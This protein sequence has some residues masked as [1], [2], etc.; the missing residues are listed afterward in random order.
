M[1]T[2]ANLSL[3]QMYYPHD[4]LFTYFMVPI[5]DT[6]F[7]VRP[8]PKDRLHRQTSHDASI[9]LLARPELPDQLPTLPPHNGKHLVHS[10]PYPGIGRLKLHVHPHHVIVNAAMKWENLR[11]RPEKRRSVRLRRERLREEFI[12]NFLLVS[13][14]NHLLEG[15]TGSEARAQVERLLE[16]LYE[17]YK[18]WTANLGDY[19]DADGPG[20][21]AGDND[22]IEDG[23]DENEED[24][25]YE[26]P[27][28]QGP[29]KRPLTLFT[30]PRLTHTI[31]RTTSVPGLPA[32]ISV[33][34]SSF[35]TF[36]TRLKRTGRRGSKSGFRTSPIAW[37]IQ[38]CD[39]SRCLKLASLTT[40]QETAA[41]APDGELRAYQTEPAR[42][43]DDVAWWPIWNRTYSKVPMPDPW[44]LG[45]T[46]CSNDWAF[47]W[48]NWW[49]PTYR[50]ETEAEVRAK[51]GKRRH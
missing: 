18:A 4:V 35:P 39:S 44:T 27:S 26:S 17:I 11:S 51:A 45:R 7:I 30:A 21:H 49:L 28:P 13:H 40:L 8:A 22:H 3:S 5:R 32:L 24:S 1:D 46:H 43:S 38:R 6:G 9:P 23:T 25:S 14:T 10:Y 19:A 42:A 37:T 20:D 16:Q 48:G 36:P 31:L 34:A 47:L 15:E 33:L 29:A 12:G 2:G 41:R 50:P